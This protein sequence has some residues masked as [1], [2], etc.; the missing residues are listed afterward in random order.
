[1]RITEKLATNTAMEAKAAMSRMM[2]VIC[3]SILFMF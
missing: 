2:S 1:M 3:L